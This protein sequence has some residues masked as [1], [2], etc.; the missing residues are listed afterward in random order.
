MLL[1]HNEV[2]VEWHQLCAQTLTLSVVSEEPLIPP[3]RAKDI[4]MDEGIQPSCPK[5]NRAVYCP[6]FLGYYGHI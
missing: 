1:Q 3:V 4:M 2:T 5:Y 6:W